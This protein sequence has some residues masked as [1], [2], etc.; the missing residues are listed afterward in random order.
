MW[1]RRVVAADFRLID[2]QVARPREYELKSS[3]EVGG[4]RL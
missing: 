3:P 2:D 1:D 4:K